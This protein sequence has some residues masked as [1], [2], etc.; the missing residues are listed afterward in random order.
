MEPLAREYLRPLLREKKRASDISKW[1][2]YLYLQASVDAVKRNLSWYEANAE[3]LA[4]LPNGDIPSKEE[5]KA[6][7]TFIEDDPQWKDL[8]DSSFVV[9]QYYRLLFK[10][11]VKRS[12]KKSTTFGVPLPQPASSGA[13]EKDVKKHAIGQWSLKDPI[14]ADPHLEEAAERF[15]SGDFPIGTMTQTTISATSR[16]RQ[17]LTTQRTFISRYLSP[18]LVF[19]YLLTVAIKAGLFSFDPSTEEEVHLDVAAWGDGVTWLG[20]PSIVVLGFF[21]W[22]PLYTKS[23]LKQ[24]MDTVRMYPLAIVVKEES[25]EAVSDVMSNVALRISHIPSFMFRGIRYFFRFRMLNGDNSFLEKAI[26]NSI[27]GHFKCILCTA[28]FSQP[29]L[30]WQFGYLVSRQTKSLAEILNYWQVTDGQKQPDFGL[31]RIPPLLGKT[32]LD[33]KGINTDTPEGSWIKA[34]IIGLDPLH[35]GRGHLGTLLAFF[36][37][38]EGWDDDIFV[39]NLVNTVGRKDVSELDGSHVRYLFVKYKTTIL[40]A[41][42]PLQSRDYEK[43]QQIELMLKTW[44]EVRSIYFF[45]FSF[46]FTSFTF[47]IDSVRHVLRSR[48]QIRS[49]LLPAL[50]CDLVPVLSTP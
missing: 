46:Y 24:W 3:L 42:E 25:I 2:R 28:D 30:L 49:F 20:V 41:W 31:R 18:A 32:L 8:P 12:T 39:C 29:K 7:Q 15:A 11:H 13:I 14:E 34:F 9:W 48:G 19:A 50:S 37:V 4:D 43:Y 17:R 36:R 1:L 27:G 44:T 40:P 22:N 10:G 6:W 47:S 23:S 16:K 26:G 45:F 5:Q 35:N 21:V 33:L 38:T